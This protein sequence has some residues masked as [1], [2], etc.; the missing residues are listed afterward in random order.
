[1]D[2]SP[3]PSPPRHPHDNGVVLR[4]E[5]SWPS[6][7]WKGVEQRRHERLPVQASR[8]IALRLLDVRLRPCSRWLLA[9]ILDISQGGMCLMVSE[10]QPFELGQWLSLDVRSHPAFGQL[11]IEVSLQWFVHAHGFTTLGVSFLAPL[12]QVPRLEVERR[13]VR[14]DPNEEAW[15][16]E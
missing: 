7:G 5:Q 11:R 1:M 14:R 4:P 15:A 3:D 12:P 10:V 2:Q 9:D 6:V 8:P 13:T 16:T